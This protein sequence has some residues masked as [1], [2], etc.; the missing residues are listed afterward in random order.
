MNRKNYAITSEFLI[1][2]GLPSEYCVSSLLRSEECL[3][4]LILSSFPFRKAENAIPT[5]TLPLA[6]ARSAV[7]TVAL[8]TVWLSVQLSGHSG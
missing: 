8:M 1:I 5:K 6:V 4:T 2:N 7:C 3:K